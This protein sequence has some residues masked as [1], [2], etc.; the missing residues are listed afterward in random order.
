[1]TSEPKPTAGDNRRAGQEANGVASDHCSFNTVPVG[2]MP[3]RRAPFLKK[4]VL[5]LAEVGWAH[6]EALW[7]LQNGNDA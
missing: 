2:D 1:M 7:T 6:P 4:G 5:Q 3:A